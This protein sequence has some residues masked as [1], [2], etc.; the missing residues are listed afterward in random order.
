VGKSFSSVKPAEFPQFETPPG[1]CT[2]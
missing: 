2:I 1:R